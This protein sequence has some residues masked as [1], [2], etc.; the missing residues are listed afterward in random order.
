MLF[1]FGFILPHSAKFIQFSI[2]VYHELLLTCISFDYIMQCEGCILL[3]TYF[4]GLTWDWRTAGHDKLLFLIMEQRIKMTILLF[5]RRKIQ[6][7][8]L[9]DDTLHFLEF[10][11]QEWN[12][13]SLRSFETAPQIENLQ[14]KCLLFIWE[15]NL[16]NKILCNRV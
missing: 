2:S 12:L 11:K 7:Y 16:C 15:P 14:L 13:L 6:Y 10:S 5:Q 3:G 1:L 9:F 8:L 4:P